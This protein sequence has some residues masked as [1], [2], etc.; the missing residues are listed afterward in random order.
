MKCN[1]PF[2]EN[3]SR[4]QLTSWLLLGQNNIKI[5]N[6]YVVAIHTVI[7][8]LSTGIFTTSVFLRWQIA[9]R[10]KAF[11]K[12]APTGNAAVKGERQNDWMLIGQE[13]GTFF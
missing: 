1:E 3:K 2:K 8:V 9:A 4:S 6:F 11:T 12:Y 5:I 7:R 13:D 10:K